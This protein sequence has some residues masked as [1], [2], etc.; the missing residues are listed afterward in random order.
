MHKPLFLSLLLIPLAACS[1]IN[2]DN[3]GKLHT[4]MSLAEIQ[5]VLGKPSQC[6]EILMIKKC[7][8]GNEQHYISVSFAADTAMATS[9][10]GL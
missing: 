4:G 10:S 5:G 2:A 8:W 6:T 1:P 3:Y 7:T 9:A